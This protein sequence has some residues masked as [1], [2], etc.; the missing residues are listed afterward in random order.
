VLFL[1]DIERFRNIN[2]SLGRANGDVLLRQMAEFLTASAGN[3]NL[4]A[5]LGADQFAVVLPAIRAD[6]DISHLLE[7]WMQVFLQ[8]PFRLNETVFHISAKVGVALYPEDGSEADTLLRNAEVAIKKAKGSG[9]R[10][11]FHTRKMSEAMAGRLKLETQLRQAIDNEEFVLHYQPK[12]N[13]VSGKVSGAEAL[14][15][16]NDPQTGLVPP[17]KF[18]P[19][20]EETGMINEVGRWALNKAMADYLRW[21]AAGLHPVRIAVNVSPMQLRN[22]GFLTELQR[23]IDQTPKVAS[24]LELE[25]TESVIMEDVT[26]TIAILNAI[27]AMGLT[28]AIDDFGTGFSSL[29]YLA[30]LPVD[31]LKID[32]S[33]VIDMTA[34]PQGL[35]LVSTIISLAHALKF[36]VVAEGVETK[37]QSHLLQLLSCDEMQGF[38]F[39]KAVPA[40]IFETHYLVPAA[41]V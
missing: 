13:L 31:T 9:E 15:R 23:S 21:H 35:A 4:V 11:M 5:R 39:S 7:K 3:A 40:D 28:I 22:R 41:T 6:G 36:K 17:A 19:I 2:D 38:L 10:Y 32:R 30:N 20:L 37:E 8:H 29:S 18:I 27:R 1:I 14:I 16:W 12:V 33:F 25:V 24:G 34:R 26:N